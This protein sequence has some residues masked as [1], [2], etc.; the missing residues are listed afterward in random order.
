MN[1]PAGVLDVQRTAS[2][3]ASSAWVAANAGSGKTHVLAQRVIRLLLRGTAPEKILC[4]TY[5]K[6]AAANMANRVFETLAR[7]TPLSDEALD[8]EVRKIEGHRPDAARRTRARRLFAQALDTPGGLKVQTIHAFCTRLLHQ[9]P[10]EADVAARFEVLEERTRSE[11][12][13]RLRMGVLLEA[14]AKPDSDLGRA[15]ATAIT[16]AADQTFAEAIDEA[17]AK[18]DELEAWIANAG[19][20]AAAIAELS[21]ALGVG[22]QVTIEEI[23]TAMIDDALLPQSEWQSV[24]SLCR[25]S[26]TNDQRQCDRLS[27]AVVAS[28]RERVNAYVSVFLNDKWEKRKAVITGPLAKQHPGLAARLTAEQERVCGLI[29][30]RRAVETRERTAALVTI[31]HEVIARYRAEKNRRGLLDYDD[32]IEKALHLL[33]AEQSAWV[34]Y[35]LDLGIDHV[36]IDEAQDTSPKQWEIVKRL[37]AEFAAGKGAREVTR[38]VFAVGD[39]KQSIFSFQGAQPRQFDVSKRHFLTAFKEAELRFEE[40]KFQYSFRS[41]PVILHAVD[42]VFKSPQA[43]AGLTEH[44]EKTLHEAVRAN[45]PG[46]VELWP[47][48]EPDEKLDIEGWDAPFDE[49]SETS[50]RIRLARKIA[51][52]VKAWIARRDAVG[53]GAARRAVRPGDILVLVRQRGALFEAIISELKKESI[54]VAGADRLTLTE[55]IAAMDLI[56]LADALLLPGDDLAL[57]CVLKSPLFGLTEE[58]LF[59]LAYGRKGTL[60]AALREKAADLEFMEANARLTRY[61]EWARHHSPFAFYARILGPDKGRARLYAR[62]GPEAADALDEFLEHALLY[63]RQEAPTLQGFVAWLRAGETQVKRDMDIARDEVRV[64]TVHGAKG[65]EAPIVILADT[66]TPPKGPREPRMLNMPVANATPGTPDRIVWA[67][68]KVDDVAPVAAARAV[69]VG[70]AEDEY[71]RLLYVAMTRAAD[72]LV[73]AGS[74]GVNRIPPG[75]WYELIADALKPEATEE[76]ADDGDGTVLRW[77]KSADAGAAEQAARAPAPQR[78]D[79]PAWLRHNAPAET[80]LAAAISPSAGVSETAH[81]IGDSRGLARGRIVHRLLQA[82][83]ALSPERRAEAAQKPFARIKDFSDAERNAIIGEVLAVLGDARFAPLFAPGSRAEVPIVGYVSHGGHRQRVSGQVDRLAVT[84]SAVLIADYKSDRAVP[85][86]AGAIPQSYVRQLALYRAVLRLLYPNH[87]VR[88]ALVWTLGPVLI[89]VP[90]A[91][92]DAELSRLGTGKNTEA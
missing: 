2:D 13:D 75:C 91:M 67:G 28:G 16:V 18:H 51:R 6:A 39:E 70:A 24:A 73:V 66:T 48:V 20:V 68:R 15:L 27:A 55:H 8:E 90:A 69:A 61:A 74:R 29:A 57:G 26:S 32:L 77:R 4:L 46:T 59:A 44:P 58:Q 33:S 14:A 50:P 71:R 7:W 54:E 30:R 52:T 72:R 89:E 92:L 23:D 88:A 81:S 3:P 10:F 42:E 62:L 21:R 40:V 56:A 25:A 36:L 9:F 64:M 82:L 87:E 83:P 19:G 45:A 22:T 60:R 38:S 43:H 79:V 34:H 49:S 84:G 41:S 17:I 5:T 37:T 11:L 85:R 12:I 76:P 86:D 78:H 53:E 80:A 31:A 65:L 1:I 35:K 63:E 47:M